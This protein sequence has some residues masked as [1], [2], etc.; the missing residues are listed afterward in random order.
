MAEV[1]EVSSNYSVANM[2]EAPAEDLSDHII[3][4]IMDQSQFV[5]SILG[6]MSNGAT[7]ITLKLML[8][9]NHFPLPYC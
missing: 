9:V 7:F 6:L 5:M 1:I 2:T 8:M 4:K 3:F